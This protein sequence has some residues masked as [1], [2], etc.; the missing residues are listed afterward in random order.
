MTRLSRPPSF[1]R[2][3]SRLSVTMDRR[4][5]EVAVLTLARR[6][7]LTFYDASYLELGLRESLPLATLDDD[8]AKAARREGLALVGR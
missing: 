4:P 5:D 8:L 1:L 2:I 7:L 3:L 6:H